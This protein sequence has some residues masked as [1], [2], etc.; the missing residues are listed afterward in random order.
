MKSTLKER[1]STITAALER[2]DSEY[3][4]AFCRMAPFIFKSVARISRV[5][6]ASEEDV[7]GEVLCAFSAALDFYKE[8]LYRYKKSL[9]RCC[10]VKGTLMLLETPRVNTRKRSLWVDRSEVTEVRR[11]KFFD[12]LYK[13]IQH[14]CFDLLSDAFTGKRDVSTPV[15]YVESFDD[16]PLAQK[17]LFENPENLFSAAQ[18][19]HEIVPQLSDPARRVLDTLMEGAAASE[20]AVAMGLRMPVKRVKMAKQEILRAFHRTERSFVQDVDLQP[21]YLRASDL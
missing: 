17:G 18:I 2:D 5:T 15:V 7:L 11:A 6:G 19:Y 10:E 20:M 14:S 8:P 12:F 16:Y 3:A 9:Y 13:R 4:Q 1:L 21:I